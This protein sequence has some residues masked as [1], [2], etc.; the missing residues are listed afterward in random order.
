MSTEES[1]RDQ[2]ALDV[3]KTKLAEA[4]RPGYKLMLLFP[5]LCL[6]GVVTTAVTDAGPFVAL[7]LLCF[8]L[9]V[10]LVGYQLFYLPRSLRRQIEELAGR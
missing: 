8:V 1:P 5:I 2:A 3:A 7:S 4:E 6:S 9:S 10:L